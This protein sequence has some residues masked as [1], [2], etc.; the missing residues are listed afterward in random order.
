VVVSSNLQR[1]GSA[2][3]EKHALEE[4]AIIKSV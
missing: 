1:F 3:E 2:K 4:R